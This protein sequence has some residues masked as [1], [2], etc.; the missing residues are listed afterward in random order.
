MIK[1]TA[2]TRVR[3]QNRLIREVIDAVGGQKCWATYTLYLQELLDAVKLLVHSCCA[4][5]NAREVWSS[6]YMPQHPATPFCNC[7]W[8]HGWAAVVPKVFHFAIISP[9]LDCGIVRKESC[10]RTTLECTELILS[11]MFVKADCMTGCLI[12]CTCG[13]AGPINSTLE[14]YLGKQSECPLVT[15]CRLELPLGAVKE[16]QSRTSTNLLSE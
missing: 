11:Q 6:Q 8:S 9:K 15:N 2:E 12:L 5:V 3:M 14:S 4:D 1:A 7:T 10:Y 16:L 13:K